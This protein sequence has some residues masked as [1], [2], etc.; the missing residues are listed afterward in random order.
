MSTSGVALALA[1]PLQHNAVVMPREMILRALAAWP[2]SLRALAREMDVPDSTLVRIRAGALDASP[3]VA[4][5]LASALEAAGTECQR[6]ARGLRRS[7][8]RRRV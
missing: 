6:A 2:G 7:L 5:R 3:E 4:A 1:R 8:E